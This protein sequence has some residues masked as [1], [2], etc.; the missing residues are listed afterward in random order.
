[1]YCIH[2][3]RSVLV[4]CR[5]KVRQCASVSGTFADYLLRE[6]TA[7]TPV[8]ARRQCSRIASCEW[9]YLAELD[10]F[11]SFSSLSVLFVSKFFCLLKFFHVVRG[12]S[13]LADDFVRQG[14]QAICSRNRLLLRSVAASQSS[15]FIE[16]HF[17]SS[18]HAYGRTSFSRVPSIQLS[19]MRRRLFIYFNP[20]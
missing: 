9:V 19:S 10:L 4:T 3:R 2:S 1:M 15:L 7:P 20:D 6:H 5:I 11:P 13:C 18:S 8:I 12:N 16:S 17:I 14:F